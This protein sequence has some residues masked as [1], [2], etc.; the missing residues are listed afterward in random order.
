[1]PVIAIHRKPLRS[2]TKREE[3]VQEETVAQN[4]QVPAAAP[5]PEEVAR[6]A[7]SYWQARFGQ[8]GNAEE[9]W[10]RAERELRKRRD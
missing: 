3:L 9:D 8:N 7:Y 5:D 1:M 10:L 2:R 6:L 4:S